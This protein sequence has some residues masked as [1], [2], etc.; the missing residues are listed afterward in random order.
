M[1]ILHGDRVYRVPIGQSPNYNSKNPLLAIAELIEGTTFA[2]DREWY[3][4][5]H[6]QYLFPIDTLELYGPS[7]NDADQLDPR[8]Q[9]NK[10][11]FQKQN[12]KNITI[13][14]TQLVRGWVST[15]SW[16]VPFLRISYQAGPGT[17]LWQAIGG[18]PGTPIRLWLKVNDRVCEAPLIVPYNPAS[19]RYEIE[20]WGY[21]GPDL[22][23]VLHDDSLRALE[24]GALLINNYLVTGSLSDFE[25]EKISD[26]DMRTVSPE[27]TMH[28]IL[29][30]HIT[31]AWADTTLTHWDS[32]EGENYHYEFNMKLRGW[33]NFLAA[34]TSINPHGG[35]GNLDYRNLLSNYGR[36]NGSGELGRTIEAWSFNAFG[37]KPTDMPREEFM[38]VDYMDLHIV[39]SD[40]GIGLHRHRDNQEVF[41]MIE[42]RALMFVGDWCKLPERERSIEVRTLRSGHMAMLKGGNLH[43][44]LNATDERMILF[45]FGGYD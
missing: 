34:G 13:A 12:L 19:G 38:A 42:G 40:C 45:M 20:I 3:L 17:P 35:I 15:G 44:V 4:R 37:S 10:L 30:L 39:H 33:D 6:L 26:L 32:Q 29:P 41:L 43:G 22:R 27:C 28:P 11:D 14:P 36:F 25:Q 21:T 31:C 1:N 5:D 9:D 18:S 16:I 24:S 23:S 7:G 8:Q 2:V